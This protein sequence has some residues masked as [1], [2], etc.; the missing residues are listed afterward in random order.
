MEVMQAPHETTFMSELNDGRGADV[1][2]QLVPMVKFLNR[3]DLKTISSCQG[4]PGSILDEGGFYGHVAFVHKDDPNDYHPLA[5]VLFEEIRP[6]VAHLYDSVR[7]EM[8]LSEE[9]CETKVLP[10][11]IETIDSHPSFIGWIYFRNECIDDITKHLGCFCE[12]LRK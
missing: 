7:L 8:A 12:M 6:L 2:S 3:L 11:G 4:N 9:V 1:D 5:R 10:P